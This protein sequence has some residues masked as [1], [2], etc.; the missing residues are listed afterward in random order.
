MF[1]ARPGAIPQL[2]HSVCTCI[3]AAP[4]DQQEFLARNIIITCGRAAIMSAK[5]EPVLHEKANKKSLILNGSIML[6]C[7]KIPHSLAVHVS[8]TPTSDVVDGGLR[9]AS[10]RY[11][12]FRICLCHSC[13][14]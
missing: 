2:A 5:L 11:V 1:L 3:A 12:R 9:M 8:A 13:N 6:T 10:L 4:A 7:T 14:T